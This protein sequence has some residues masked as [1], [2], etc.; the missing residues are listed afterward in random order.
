MSKI[1]GNDFYPRP[2]VPELRVSHS[3]RRRGSSSLPEDAQSQLLVPSNHFRYVFVIHSQASGTLWESGGEQEARLAAWRERT[4]SLRN[5]ASRSQ[6][7]SDTSTLAA[8]PGSQGAIRRVERLQLVG[9]GH[10]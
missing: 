9:V 7:A 3:A 5:G 10:R 6:S 8:P 4:A 2:W 1:C